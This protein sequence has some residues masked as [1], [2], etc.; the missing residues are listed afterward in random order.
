MIAPY[1]QSIIWGRPTKFNLGSSILS[2]RA[3]FSTHLMLIDV[4]ILILF[5][6]E[7]L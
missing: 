2:M 4:I 3:T 6:E 1:M 5:D 7:K